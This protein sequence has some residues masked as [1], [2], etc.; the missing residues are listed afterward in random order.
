ML[1]QLSYSR[2]DPKLAIPVTADKQ[3][4]KL[5][6]ANERAFKGL[7]GKMSDVRIQMSEV[8][9]RRPTTVQSE[10]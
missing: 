1:Y 3:W 10:F 4:A 5:E 7:N 2:D 8:R 9:L 6:R